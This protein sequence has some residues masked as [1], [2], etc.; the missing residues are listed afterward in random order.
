MY[1]YLHR[2]S[3][4]D[5]IEELEAV[6]ADVVIQRMCVVANVT[7]VCERGVIARASERR[8]STQTAHDDHVTSSHVNAIHV[9]T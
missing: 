6:L 3:L 1:R 2:I 8:H 4:E 7:D 9:V 5:L